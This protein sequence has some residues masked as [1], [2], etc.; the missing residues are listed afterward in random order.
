MTH[1]RAV[2]LQ[3]PQPFACNEEATV[4][5]PVDGPSEAR[6]TLGDD[7]GIALEIDS[8]DLVRAPVREPQTLLVPTRRLAD[9]EV[10]QQG[11]RF[12]RG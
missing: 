8:Y 10:A 7:L 2:G 5:E 11:L 4:G 3:A 12:E 9:D 6:R 1:D